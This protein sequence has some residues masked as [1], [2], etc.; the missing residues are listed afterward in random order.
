M[1]IPSSPEKALMLRKVER[2]QG[3]WNTSK[4][5][6]LGY[7]CKECTIGSLERP[8]YRQIVVE[9]IY[10]CSGWE[11]IQNRWHIVSQSINNVWTGPSNRCICFCLLHH[12]L[13]TFS[14]SY[15]LN[16]QGNSF[17]SVIC[18]WA[19]LA[20]RTILMSRWNICLSHLKPLFLILSSGTTLSSHPASLQFFFLSLN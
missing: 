9:E 8:G 12:L 10:L 13:Y 11:S 19:V 1:W 14:S 2:N 4:V 16:H 3:E 20:I 18:N 17:Q 15:Q 7:N 6:R 5:D